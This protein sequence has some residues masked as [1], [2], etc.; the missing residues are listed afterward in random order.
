MVEPMRVMFSLS[1]GQGHLDP[2]V[3]FARAAAAAGHDVAFAGRPWMVPKVEA[4]GFTCFPAG[5]D[6]GLEPVTRP[7]APIDMGR[8]ARDLVLGFGQRVARARAPGL[9]TAFEGWR[10][11]VAV[12]DE[13]D[14]AAGIIAERLGVPHATV[15]VMAFGMVAAPFA[16]GYNAVRAAYGLEPDPS[17]KML[18]RYLVLSPF[19]ASL[20]D[21]GH[22]APP[23]T[24]RIRIV[25]ADRTGGKTGPAPDWSRAIEG[26][27][28]VYFTLGTVFNHES[29]DLFSRV[30]AGLRELRA[31]LLVTVGRE[32]D[33]ASLGPQPANVRIERFVPQSEVLPHV[34]LVVSHGGS[35]SVLGALAHGRPMVVLPIGADQPLNAVRISALGA[36]RALDAIR[37]TPDEVREAVASVL[38]DAACREAAGRLADEIA[39]LAPPGVAVAL[40]E[41]LA[42]ERRPLTVS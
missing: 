37:A 23:T 13:T 25:D 4:L 39:A 16:E 34:D 38:A 27:P 5:T 6:D 22:Q 40:L 1:G 3:P 35:G 20:H 42:R 10:P 36:G 8:E 28:S 18:S 9:L 21:P 24:H 31:N 12:W 15:Q 11:D 7:L 26:A 19:P 29:G 2:L 14:P 32:I 41:R 17:G 30:L 33:P